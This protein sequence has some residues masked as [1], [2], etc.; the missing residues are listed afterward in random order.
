[1]FASLCACSP[2]LR[3]AS[4]AS[5]KPS[6]YTDAMK[7]GTGIVMGERVGVVAWVSFPL[8]AC[9]FNGLIPRIASLREVQSLGDDF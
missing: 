2:G 8:K 6:S 1:M 9:V 3:P 5:Q 4:Q 7:L